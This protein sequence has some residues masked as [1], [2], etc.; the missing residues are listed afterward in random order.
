MFEDLTEPLFSLR[1]PNLQTDIHLITNIKLNSSIP[2]TDWELI[3]HW[4]EIYTVLLDY[5]Q[6]RVSW[7][8][9]RALGSQKD[10]FIVCANNTGQ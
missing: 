4:Y 6:F 7:N 1:K 3:A 2:V 10:L 9:T 5:V 8:L